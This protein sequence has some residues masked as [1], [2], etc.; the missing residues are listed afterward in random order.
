MEKWKS[1]SLFPGNLRLLNA[2]FNTLGYAQLD[3]GD[4]KDTP[5]WAKIR[6]VCELWKCTY[7]S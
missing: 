6:G 3:Y 5:V 7:A 2:L 1:H 4:A